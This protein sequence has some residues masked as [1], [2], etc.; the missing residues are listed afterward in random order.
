MQ[1]LS[2]Q[3]QAQLELRNNLMELK[4]ALRE[5][6]LAEGQ[7]EQLLSELRISL[8]R[9][10]R[11]SGLLPVCSACKLNMTIPADLNAINPVV[12]GV[13]EIVRAMKCASGK[14]F[15]IEAAIREA[16]A[17]AILHGC[18]N[19]AKQK[20]QCIVTC[21]ES[22]ELLIVVRDPGKG[23]EPSNLPDPLS[24]ENIHSDHGRG[25]YLIN[26]FMDEV[27]FE[28]GGRAIHMRARSAL[29]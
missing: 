26:Q 12:D 18:H 28:E 5:R 10:N 27:R 3:V 9:V 19:D 15:E 20:I 24:A 16:L 7:R 23:F 11:L 6:D 29:V 8:E 21:D 1:I 13:L 4:D 2:R 17:N 22:A 14:E 25:I